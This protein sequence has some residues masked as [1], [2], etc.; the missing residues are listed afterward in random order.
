MCPFIKF[1]VQT[2][3][4]YSNSWCS[5]VDRTIFQSL[6]TEQEFHQAK[7]RALK[8]QY[9]FWRH[10]SSTFKLKEIILG[11]LQDMLTMMADINFVGES[12]LDLT[13]GQ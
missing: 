7:W 12:N 8:W 3:F 13:C 11:D 1:V 10:Y 5:Y 6:E 9:L 2:Q 4:D